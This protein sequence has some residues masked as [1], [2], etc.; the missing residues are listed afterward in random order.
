MVTTPDIRTATPLRTCI[1]CR[2]RRPQTELARCVAGDPRARVSRTAPGRGAWLCSL[3]C[4]RQAERRRAFDR[5][6]KRKVSA[7]SLSNLDRELHFA[8]VGVV[9][10][11]EELQGVGVAADEPATEKG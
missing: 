4:L 9:I 3:D 10:N 11:M 8:L 6:W 7:E 1:G 5:A 2:Q